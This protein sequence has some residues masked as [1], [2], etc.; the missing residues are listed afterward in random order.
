MTRF[1]D[2]ATLRRI[3]S[4]VGVEE[5]LAGM[6]NTMREDFRRWESFEKLARVA[7]HSE[8]GVIELM[9]ISDQDRYA[10][11][12]VNG[13]PVNATKGVS[14]VMAFGALANVDTGFPTLLSELTVTTDTLNTKIHMPKVVHTHYT[15]HFIL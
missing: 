7:S 13:H 15:I 8:I 1:V 5:F 9:P 3:V 14:T 12:Y 4:R 2:V 6:A 11:K 10:F